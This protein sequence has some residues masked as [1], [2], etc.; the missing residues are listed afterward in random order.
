MNIPAGHQS[1]MPYLML[2]GAAKFGE[3]AKTVFGAEITFTRFRENT[4]L[5]MHSELQ[6]NGCTIMYCD[7]NADWKPQPANMFVYV[8]DA[9]AT[10]KLAC[11]N[12]CTTIMEPA[13]QDYG[14]SCGVADPFGNVWWIT[15]VKK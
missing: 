15:S 8:P 10:Y 14:R 4:E 13:D 6:I 11:A 7:S 3:F 2:P 5:V 1:L 12:G 9:D